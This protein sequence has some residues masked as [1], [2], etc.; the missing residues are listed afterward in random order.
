MDTLGKRI[1]YY[2]KLRGLSQEK[3]AEHIGISRQAVTKWENDNSSPNT[4]ICCNYPC[5]LIFH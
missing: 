2:R 3:V 5:C 4:D 1:A